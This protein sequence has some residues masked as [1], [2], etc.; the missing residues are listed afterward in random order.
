MRMEVSG[1]FRLRIVEAIAKAARTGE[2]V[3]TSRSGVTV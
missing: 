2:I 3:A 1:V